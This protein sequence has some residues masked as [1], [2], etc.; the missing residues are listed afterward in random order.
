MDKI[1]TEYNTN[2]KKVD[3]CSIWGFNR[4][5]VWI[6]DLNYQKFDDTIFFPRILVSFR[7]D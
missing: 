2:L 4:E 6:S 1:D 3:K 7:I 5:G